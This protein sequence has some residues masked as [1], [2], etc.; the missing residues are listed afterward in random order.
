[1]SNRFNFIMTSLEGLY[2]VE[3]KPIGDERGSFSRFFC[4]EEFKE[5][6]LTQPIAQMNHTVTKQKGAIRGLHYQNP[7]YTETKIVTCIR[8]EIFDVAVDVRKGSPTFL[9]WHIEVLSEK[10]RSSL[11]IPDGFAHGFQALTENCELLYIHSASY[12]DDAEAGLNVL[13]RELNIEWP[14]AISEISERDQN[15]P[16]IKTSFKGIVV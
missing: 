3:Q 16:M 7:P 1:M 8:G 11:Y 2:K 4:S 5:V 6:G 13:D 15:H 14:L 10:N 12:Q 9:K